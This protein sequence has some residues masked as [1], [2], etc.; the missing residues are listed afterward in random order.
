[1][2]LDPVTFAKSV[3]IVPDAWQVRALRH[4][5]RNLILNASRQTGKSTTAAV[6]ALHTALYKPKSLT[7]LLSPSLRQSS[8]LFR[9]ITDLFQYLQQPPE[10]TEDNRLS[11][12][13]TTGSRI[14]SL[15]SK[16][17]NIRGYSDVTLLIVDEASR[18]LESLYHSCRP[19]L[20]VSQG[21]LIL[22]STPAGKRGFF[23]TTWTNEDDTWE[24]IEVPATQCER[25]SQDFLDE[26]KR[27]LGERWFRQE[28]CCSFED[29]EG[30]IFSHKL[31]ESAFC[32]EAKPFFGSVLSDTLEP[33]I[34]EGK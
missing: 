21:S 5:G 20:A 29:V 9:K 28:Y 23:H 15:P 13:L 12:T 26:E 6:K 19:M 31:I 34:M 14:V 17:Q 32:D 8:E 33:F 2:A 10:K 11:M 7:L 3:D 16:E 18:V 4:P 30:A 25:I 27:V 24:R 22:M 1:M